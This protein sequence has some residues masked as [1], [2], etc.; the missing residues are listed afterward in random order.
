MKGY[1]HNI[2]KAAQQNKTFRTVLLNGEELPTRQGAPEQAANI[3]HRAAALSDSASFVSGSGL[4]Q[5]QR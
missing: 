3:P 5:E 1:V 4:R 2:E